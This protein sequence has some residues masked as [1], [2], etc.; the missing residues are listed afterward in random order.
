VITA[1]KPGPKSSTPL[2]GEMTKD[3]DKD[4]AELPGDDGTA[5]FA[6]AL[7]EHLHS[8][9]ARAEEAEHPLER[10]GILAAAQQEL[11]WAT[12]FAMSDCRRGG[13]SWPTM[14]GALGAT[15]STLLRQFEA[16]GPV[17]TARPAG[18]TGDNGQGPLRQ[19]AKRV[20]NA[21]AVPGAA[22]KAADAATLNTEAQLMGNVMLVVD[23]K[24]LLRAVQRVLTAGAAI[25]TTQDGP[26]TAAESRLRSA[27]RDLRKVYD[28]DRLLITAVAA[29][30]EAVVVAYNGAEVTVPLSEGSKV[31]VMLDI[32]V[33]AHGLPKE[34]RGEFALRTPHGR[35]LTEA[36]LGIR[37]EKVAVG[38]RLTLGPRP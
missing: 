33:A 18:P 17:V 23:A 1:S 6:K 38:D 24:A 5:D 37:D 35:V 14:A 31:H 11:A 36:A 32:A 10:L 20:L 19:A 13:L 26:L 2:G 12:R 21:L 30:Q 22:L 29:T 28:R 4:W 27:L 9:I 7:L 15:H 3:D 16:A 34:R 8:E 25:E